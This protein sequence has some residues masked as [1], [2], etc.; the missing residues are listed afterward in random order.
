[1]KRNR[2][3]FSEGKLKK[4][5]KMYKA[6][7][8]WMVAPIVFFSLG[9]F[10]ITSSVSAD[11]VTKQATTEDSSVYTASSENLTSASEV[12]LG[13]SSAANQSQTDV[14]SAA[15]TEDQTVSSSDAATSSVAKNDTSI[16]VTASDATSQESETAKPASEASTDST[17]ATD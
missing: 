8:S 4:R 9:A 16:A 17:T 14:A 15:T 2:N 7:K 5:Y 12:T 1:M 13:K 3:L 6:G 10:S 11:Q